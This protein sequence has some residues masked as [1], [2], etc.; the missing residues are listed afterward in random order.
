ML[1]KPRFRASLEVVPLGDRTIFLLDEHRQTI[2]E[3]AAFPPLAPLLNG[4]RSV[5]EILSCVQEKVGAPEAFSALDQLETGGYLIEG[6]PSAGGLD[7]A[8]A[9][10]FGV[11]DERAHGPVWVTAVGDAQ[12]ARLADVLRANGVTFA[13]SE[14]RDARLRV[15]VTD[16]YLRPGLADINRQSLGDGTPWMLI[17]PIGM[18]LWIG[19]LLVPGETGCWEC[20]AQR[21]RANRQMEQYIEARRVV[22]GEGEPSDEPMIVS[23]AY[24]PATLDI[25]DSLA[26]TEISK[27]LVAPQASRIVGRLISFDLT[28]RR[29]RHHVLVRRPQC[30]VCGE[31]GYRQNDGAGPPA[32]AHRKKRFT[33]DGGH[34]AVPPAETFKRFEHHISPILGAVTELRRA[35][36]FRNDLVRTYIAGHNFSLGPESFVFLRDSLR[37]MSGGKGSTDIQAKVSGL[38]EAI[39]RYSGV[40]WGDEYSITRSHEQLGDKAIHPNECMGFSEAQFRNMR[41]W[42]AA[43][44]KSRCVLIPYAFDT[45]LEVEWSPL[46]SLTNER[47]RYLPTAYCYFGHPEFSAHWCAPDSNGCAA[48]NT[49]EEAFLQGFME[50]VERDAIA[51][52]WYNRIRRRGIDL[53]SFSIPYVGAVR[54]FYRSIDRDLWALDLT[55]DFDIPTIACVSRRRTGPTD[56]L[57]LGFGAHFDAKIAL[58]RAVTEVNQSLPSVARTNPDGSTKY[59][60]DELARHWW[61]H[62]SLAGMDYLAPDEELP[63]ARLRDFDDSSSEDLYDDVQ[64]CL[65]RAQEAGLEVLVLDQTRPDIGLNVVKVVMPGM[66]HFWRRLGQSRMYQ[67]PVSM[68]WRDDPLPEDEINPFSVFF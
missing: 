18:V 31:A 39:E 51:V 38:C 65:Q 44:P 36:G 9:E 17:K 40:W 64:T 25:A 34:R 2:F 12:S 8:F 5:S 55:A 6:K 54:D 37:G 57:L 3:G 48:G 50:L 16:D 24:L 30:P 35:P 32:F 27:W 56:D 47:Y 10:Y 61:A 26:A 33:E 68:G 41:E 52:W 4:E 7:P 28:D 43:Q 49:F 29:M 20:M 63:A 21:L 58:L 46:W 14:G 42:N 67:V 60:G 53:D 13:G 1:S 45:S 66:C 19:P 11:P 59:V 62:S 22:V 15:V 23:R